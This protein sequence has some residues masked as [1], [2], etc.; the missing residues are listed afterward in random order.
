[1]LFNDAQKLLLN[2][3]LTSFCEI[4]TIR[5]PINIPGW[6]PLVKPDCSLSDDFFG[7]LFES[8]D[9]ADVILSASGR[10]LH[11]HKAVLSAR[12]PASSA[13]FI[14]MLERKSK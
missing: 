7:Q 10:L 1:M 9:F 8:C 3:R 13:M 2:D 4:S 5:D 6:P 12:S 11:V 14:H